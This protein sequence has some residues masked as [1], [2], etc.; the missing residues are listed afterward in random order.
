[1]LS[2][3]SLGA[4]IVINLIN[5]LI[6]Q[7]DQI[8]GVWIFW[9]TLSLI[10]LVLLPDAANLL[11]IPTLMAGVFLSIA[12]FVRTDLKPF[13][14]LGTLVFAVP[15]TLGLIYSLEQSQGYRLIV[16]VL[17]LIGLYAISLSPLLHG[18]SLKKGMIVSLTGIIV[19]LSIVAYKPLYTEWRPQHV[20]INYIENLDSGTATYNLQSQNP[21]SE[22]LKSSMDFQGNRKA[23][24]PYTNRT[25]NNW[26]ET[27]PT[28]WQNPDFKI[29]NES[30]KNNQREIEIEIRSLRAADKLLL[31]VPANSQLRKFKL[32][33]IEY[34]A[35]LSSYFSDDFFAIR[36]VGVYE[37]LIVLTLTFDSSAPITGAYLADISTELPANAEKILKNRTK[38]SVPS[39]HGGDTATLFRSISF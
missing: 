12:A 26:A 33:E 24:L 30:I 27:I 4:L 15:S 1:L 14:F 13:A 17:P 10:C 16:A 5:R 32:N 21:I 29:L 6:N 2:S 31:A 23:L 36:L 20:N 18:V 19:S 35:V 34:E 25:S 37:K 38:L 22:N 28:D 8:I 11:I 3:T 7:N 39:G 9:W